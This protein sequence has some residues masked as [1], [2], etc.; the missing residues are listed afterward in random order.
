V[1]NA[2]TDSKGNY[3]F[4]R[5]PLVNTRYQVVAKTGPPTT[6]AIA[7]ES[8]KFFVSLKLS[9]AT[10]SSGQN[11]RFSGVV[12]PADNGG[13]V[14]IQRKTSSGWK[15]ISKTLAKPSTTGQSKYAKKVRIT[16]AGLYRVRAP[17][18]SSYATGTSPQRR[19]RF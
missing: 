19:I 12:R 16:H 3:T 4:S 5:K 10:I 7:Q 17:G 15:T 2:T 8:V 9:D 6:S 11:V 14:R 13:L 1:A 18:N